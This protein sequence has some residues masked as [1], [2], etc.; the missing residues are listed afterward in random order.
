MDSP[1]FMADIILIFLRFI[2][3]KIFSLKLTIITIL[4]MVILLS[5]LLPVNSEA[6]KV[7]LKGIFS[8]DGKDWT[9]WCK[10]ELRYDC[11][12]IVNI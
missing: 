10:N 7:Y 8:L 1:C 4:T 2:M 5:I 9:C 12:C 6:K 11:F 3:R